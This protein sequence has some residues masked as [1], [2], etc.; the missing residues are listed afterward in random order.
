MT[1]LSYSW[2]GYRNKSLVP[3]EEFVEGRCGA[4]SSM[5]FPPITMVCCGKQKAL[6]F[7]IFGVREKYD[8]LIFNSYTDY[9]FDQLRY[10]NYCGVCDDGFGHAWHDEKDQDRELPY[11]VALWGLA[12]PIRTHLQHTFSKIRIPTMPPL[13]RYRKATNIAN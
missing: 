5:A 13:N 9:G 3:D 7:H 11:S 12:P 8:R 2:I 10:R 6:D 4:T 1:G